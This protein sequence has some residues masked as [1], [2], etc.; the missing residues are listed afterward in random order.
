MAAS[1]RPMSKRAIAKGRR[2][3]AR[4]AAAR[5]ARA[6]PMPARP[7]W[8]GAGRRA[9]RQHRPITECRITTMRQ[10]IARRLTEIEADRP[11]FLSHHRLRDRRAAARSR[12]EAS[13]RRAATQALGQ[14]FRHQGGGAGAAARCR[15]PMPPG[16]RTRSCA[17][18]RS[19][20]RSRS[21]STDGLITPIISN[22]DT[23]GPCA[24]SA[25]MKDLAARA[26]DGK[27]K[28]EE[29]QGGTF[30]I[31]NL[32]MF[33]IRDF[34]AVINPPQGCI[35]AVGAGEQRPVVKNGALA[36]A[37]VM[38]CTLS[39]RPPRRRRRDRRAMMQ[40][41]KKLIEAPAMLRCELT[42]RGRAISG[43]RKRV[44]EFRTDAVSG[45][46]KVYGRCVIRSQEHQLGRSDHR[47]RR[48][49]GRLCRGD[50]RGAARHED[51]GR[52]ARAAGRHLP[53]LGLH[54]DQGA[55]A[56]RRRSTTCC[57]I[58]AITASPP[59]T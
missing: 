46:E 33:G 35:L 59:R 56:H 8:H 52:R 53:Q 45:H 29:F 14:R 15:R 37:T 20:S 51:G 22:A 13:T 16:A 36:I 38:S 23:E 49:A 6:R 42:F 57:T 44:P 32:G 28:L 19:T 12:A 54:P 40:A 41:F 1:S 21:R 58:S 11:A 26:R 9:R 3:A 24:I 43:P 5:A 17:G 2:D 25:E 18:M 39:V 34:A 7:A 27:L 50:P 10:V 47:N 31:S 48:R 30:S 4:A 55:A